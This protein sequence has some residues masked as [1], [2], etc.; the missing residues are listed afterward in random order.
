MGHCSLGSPQSWVVMTV[1]GHR[2]ESIMNLGVKVWNVVPQNIR[3]SESN[4]FKSKTKY[5][6]PNH[7]PCQICKTY[8]AKLVL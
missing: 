7:C 4:I 1:M 3:S 8:I 6:T 5:W 2:T